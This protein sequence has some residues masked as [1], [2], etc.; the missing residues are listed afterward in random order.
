MRIVI[1]IDGLEA[2]ATTTPR[3][4]TGEGSPGGATSGATGMAPE[5]LRAAATLGAQ[6]AGPAPAIFG[7]AG[8]MTGGMAAAVPPLPYTGAGPEVPTA[9]AGDLSAGTAPGAEAEASVPFTT[10]EDG[11]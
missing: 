11:R 5:S 9:G 1:E 10:T 7:A 8:G 3:A 4:A 6:D 2:T